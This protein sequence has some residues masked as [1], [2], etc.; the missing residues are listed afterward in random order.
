MTLRSCQ[1][2][3]TIREPVPE[4]VRN[5]T[6]TFAPNLCIETAPALPE[7]GSV[8]HVLMHDVLARN[9]L[10]GGRVAGAALKIVRQ[11]LRTAQPAVQAI[12]P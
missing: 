7:T 6:Y 12:S 9:T 10:T 2:S 4:A 3:K 5:L 1:H 11:T 8:R